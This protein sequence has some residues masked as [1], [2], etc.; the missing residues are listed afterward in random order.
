M[1]TVSVRTTQNVSIEYPIAGVGNRILAYVI[2]ALIIFAYC[3][4]LM[5]GV[6][7][8]VG[9]G[10]AAFLIIILIFLPVFFYHLLFEI[11]MNGQS[12]GK[13][14]VGIRVIRLDGTPATVGNYLLRWLF[15]PIECNALGV[16]IIA[17]S[18]KG[19]RIGDMVAGT[20]VIKVAPQ[21]TPSTA[22][23]IGLQTEPD[24]QPLYPQVAQ[25]SDA[26]IEII[27]Q[28]LAASRDSGNRSPVEAA[29]ERV[30]SRLG[31]NSDFP[32]VK[33]LYTVL[34]D[35]THLMEK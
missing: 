34:R 9:S 25:L 14:Q 30:K 8:N 18:K 10:A 20:T 6:L 11:F 15:R 13:R 32:A 16:I 27:R 29:A 2:D 7:Q 3:A 23:E 19:Q 22:D 5:F 33:F 24:Y 4:V 35:Y 17:V 1:T 31:I 28:A 12:P 26:D 21:D